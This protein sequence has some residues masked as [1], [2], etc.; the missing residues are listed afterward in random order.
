MASATGIPDQAV[1]PAEQES[2][3][4]EPLLGQ[5]GAASQ[6]DG[7]PLYHNVIIG[8]SLRLPQLL[9]EQS[10]KRAL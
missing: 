1:I 10:R 7:R 3:E 4:D 6:K 2:T 5:P 8:R 9:T